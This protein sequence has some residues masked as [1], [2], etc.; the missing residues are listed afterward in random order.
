MGYIAYIFYLRQIPKETEGIKNLVNSFDGFCYSV[1]S[2][3]LE[4]IKHK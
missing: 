1:L 4:N 2:M 3:P